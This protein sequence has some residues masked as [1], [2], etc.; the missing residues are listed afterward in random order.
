MVTNFL[1]RE[2]RFFLI[3]SVAL[4][5]GDAIIGIVWAF[6][7]TYLN[8][9]LIPHLHSL[10]SVRYGVDRD[11]TSSWNYLQISEKCCGVENATE[12][13]NS[14]WLKNLPTLKYQTLNTKSSSSRPYYTLPA[15]CCVIPQIDYTLLASN[16]LNCSVPDLN[17][18]SLYKKGC[19]LA[20]H[21]WMHSM[22]DI[23]F[24]LGYSV[25]AFV[26][27]A[28]V[29]CLYN[30]IKHFIR[31]IYI[32]GVP[33]EMHSASVSAGSDL[34]N[35]HRN[36]SAAGKCKAAS[37]IPAIRP[38]DRS[39]RRWSFIRGWRGFRDHIQNRATPS[40]E[41]SPPFISSHS[42]VK[43]KSINEETTTMLWYSSIFLKFYLLCALT[44][45]FLVLPA[46]LWWL[47]KE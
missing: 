10:L 39:L 28:L 19:Y 31:K 44:S 5:A 29:F 33:R 35:F 26:R 38:R 18:P 42:T 8:G 43:L 20:L 9:K 36:T 4:C 23:L 7:F 13:S 1:R 24:V 45:A 47:K 3:F 41:S 25:I 21:A 12:Y 16:L 15:S 27:A 11:F 17:S 32:R 34:V 22:G 2:I 37:N 6:K 40:P 14:I 46:D 30:E